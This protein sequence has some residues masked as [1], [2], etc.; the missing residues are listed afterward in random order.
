MLVR[1]HKLG[2]L[3]GGGVLINEV[4]LGTTF[5]G[6]VAP[7]VDEG[8]IK[9]CSGDSQPCLHGGVP[10]VGVG[11]EDPFPRGFPLQ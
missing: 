8:D 7:R 5:L 3:D 4:N 2:A 10:S 1:L 6:R 9:G 11:P